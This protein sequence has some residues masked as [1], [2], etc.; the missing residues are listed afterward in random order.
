MSGAII[1]DLEER[2]DRLTVARDELA[3][4]VHFLRDALWQTNKSIWRDVKLS[5]SAQDALDALQ[6]WEE[7]FVSEWVEVLDG[8]DAETEALP[9]GHERPSLGCSS[10]N[11]RRDVVRELRKRFEGLMGGKND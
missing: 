1:K 11:W 6:S 3:A 10:Y 2:V 7:Q 9:W 4:H 8:Y 5:A